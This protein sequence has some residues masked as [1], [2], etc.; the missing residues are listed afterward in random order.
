[1]V[2][3]RRREHLRPLAGAEWRRAAVEDIFQRYMAVTV[4]F[5]LGSG[6]LFAF[7]PTFGESLGVHTLSL[8]YTAY[9]GAAIAVRVVGGRLIDTRGRRAVIVP[10]MF[11]QACATGILAVVGLVLD[12]AGTAPVLPMLIL[13][14][15][16]AGASHGFLYPGLAALVADQTPEARRGVVVGFFSAVFLAGNAGGAFVFGYV[17]HLV[18]YGSM[19]GFLSALLLVGLLLSLRLTDSRA[20]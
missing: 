18:G 16:M 9:A 6:T 12:R 10:S 20:A 11:L 17:T 14:G 13:T 4:F 8:F 7:M 15:L 1:G 19:W 5:G 3:E 2:R